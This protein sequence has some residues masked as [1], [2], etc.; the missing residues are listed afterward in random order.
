MKIRIQQL[1]V[2]VCMQRPPLI[3]NMDSR[4]KL[5]NIFQS[6]T[7]CVRQVSSRA[8]EVSCCDWLRGSDEIRGSTGI[9]TTLGSHRRWDCYV[10][11]LTPGFRKSIWL[12]FCFCRSLFHFFQEPLRLW[13]LFHYIESV[14]NMSALSTHSWVRC[15]WRHLN[16]DP[17]LFFRVA[18]GYPKWRQRREQ[19]TETHSCCKSPDVLVKWSFCGGLLNL[20][21][22]SC[23][24]SISKTF[25][26]RDLC[27]S[28]TSAL[29]W[30]LMI[31]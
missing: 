17:M 31:V 28:L 19:T 8:G 16:L 25:S 1:C 9:A 23:A 12:Q 24:T 2:S 26:L 21:A 6:D 10:W 7:L 3:S 15:I 29:G 20:Q 30:E 13:I 14:S 11:M 5:S 27:F 4:L 18:W 22:S